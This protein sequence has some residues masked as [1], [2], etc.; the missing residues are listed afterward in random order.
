[1]SQ[2]VRPISPHL[3][4]YRWPLSMGLS[5]LHRA[6]GIVMSVG[7]LVLVAYLCALA[8]GQT[9]FLAFLHLAASWPCQVLLIG[10]T[11]ALCFHLCNGV[12]HLFWDTGFGYAK[13]RAHATGVVVAIASIVVTVLI[14]T[15]V[16]INRGVL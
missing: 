16:L 7:T 14:W 9:Q 11:W 6:T 3:Q 2:A 12:R 8:A 4:V 13:H 15:T 10:W 1:M 5:I